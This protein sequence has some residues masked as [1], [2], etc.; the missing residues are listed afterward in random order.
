MW[1]NDPKT[2]NKNGEKY[3]H[4]ICLPAATLNLVIVQTDCFVW[5]RLVDYF[6]RLWICTFCNYEVRI[7]AWAVSHYCKWVGGARFET[8]R[9]V[10]TNLTF[11][12]GLCKEVL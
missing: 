12:A 6:L 9:G 1:T 4:C 2:M 7:V 11:T 3:V 10:S 5:F 8:G